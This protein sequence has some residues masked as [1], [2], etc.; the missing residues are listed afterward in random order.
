MKVIL[1]VVAFLTM[2]PASA[3]EVQKYKP[4]D[5]QMAD[6]ILTKL[7]NKLKFCSP[8]PR[9]SAGEY[10]ANRVNQEIGRELMTVYRV[11]YND[12]LFTI[13][14]GKYKIGS[15]RMDEAAQCT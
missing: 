5:P 7:S 6:R 2:A 1:L 10:S 14:Y 8:Q 13:G 3:I 9:D 4:G 11:Y 12:G 15:A